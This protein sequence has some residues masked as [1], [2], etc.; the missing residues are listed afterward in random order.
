MECHH[1]RL[2]RTKQYGELFHYQPLP[3]LAERLND[4]Q[5]DVSAA[6]GM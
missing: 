2:G 3:V 6:S 5:P 1:E 4:W